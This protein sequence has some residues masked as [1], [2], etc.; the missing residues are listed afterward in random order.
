MD[1]AVGRYT[2]AKPTW[3]LAS[4][5]VLPVGS[6]LASGNLTTPLLVSVES[7]GR[8]GA[9][10]VWTFPYRSVYRSTGAYPWPSR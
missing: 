10:V 1:D 9:T 6:T 8:N 4:R 5:A 3:A 2:P 7:S